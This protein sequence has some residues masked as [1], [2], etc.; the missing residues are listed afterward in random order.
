[1]IKQSCSKKIFKYVAYRIFQKVMLGL[2]FHMECRWVLSESLP[3]HCSV[4][5]IILHHTEVY[6]E[7]GVLLALFFLQRCFKCYR[8]YC[9]LHWIYKHSWVFILGR[10]LGRK[11]ICKRW[12]LYL[13]ILFIFNFLLVHF[14]SYEGRM[15]FLAVQYLIFICSMVTVTLAM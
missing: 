3:H 9:Y 8:W 11:Y 4:I 2:F 15:H 12:R 13:F 6:S 7:L 10:Y 1:M 14:N 5:I